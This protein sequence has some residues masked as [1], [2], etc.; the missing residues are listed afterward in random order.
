MNLFKFFLAFLVLGNLVLVCSTK[1]LAQSPT[2][3]NPITPEPPLQI[4]KPIKTPQLETPPTQTTPSPFEDIPGTIKV[5]KFEFID[6]TAFS[7]EELNE[8]VKYLINKEITFADLIQV[9]SIISNLYISKG[10][11]NSGA[12]IEAGQARGEFLSAPGFA[13]D[14]RADR[15]GWGSRVGESA[16]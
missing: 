2:Q 10:Y 16:A 6:N 9:E 12:V 11:I 13:A 4:P 3:L 1:L 5:T 15:P 7:D 8:F 14:Q